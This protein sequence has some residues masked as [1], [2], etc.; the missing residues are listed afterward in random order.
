MQ[1]SIFDKKNRFL[2]VT[3]PANPTSTFNIQLNLLNVKP[4]HQF[5]LPIYKPNTMLVPNPAQTSVS[6]SH[7]NL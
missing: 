4:P 1:I 6:P 5:S 3:F 2:Q 7:L